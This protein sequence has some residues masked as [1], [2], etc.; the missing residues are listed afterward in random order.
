MEPGWKATV[1]A[2][3]DID[4]S[5]KLG[6]DVAVDIAYDASGYPNIYDRDGY[7]AVAFQ[8]PSRATG[9][10]VEADEACPTASLVIVDNDAKSRNTPGE[11]VSVEFSMFRPQP[12]APSAEHPAT[13]DKPG[14][15]GRC[16]G[17][18]GRNRVR[19]AR[20]RT[21]R[22]VRCAVCCGDGVSGGGEQP[23]LSAG[24]AQDSA[25]RSVHGHG[26]E[27][28]ER[29]GHVDEPELDVHRPGPCRAP[30][31][32]APPTLGVPHQPGRTPETGRVDQRRRCGVLDAGLHPARAAPALIGPGC[33]LDPRPGTVTGI[34]DANH[35]DI[36]QTHKRLAHARRDRFPQGLS[37]I[38]GLEN[39]RFCRVLVPRPRM[40]QPITAPRSAPKS[41]KS[42]R[43]SASSSRSDSR[44]R[45]NLP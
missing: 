19:S 9:T 14:G 32:G 27:A 44:M 12:M 4:P 17:C 20:S 15:D 36:G 10:H 2:D 43:S 24:V 37:R 40:S 31:L 45:G 18:G 38:V 16:S 1:Q 26:V 28:V 34:V 39:L 8:D 25:F 42:S 3:V 6:D 41:P 11:A 21:G 30:G 13:I 35:V 29:A 22:W 7:T 33:H 5:A 23:V